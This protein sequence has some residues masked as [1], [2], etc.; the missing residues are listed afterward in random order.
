MYIYI[1]PIITDILVPSISMAPIWIASVWDD[2]VKINQYI[3]KKFS[4]VQ[5]SSNSLGVSSLSSLAKSYRPYSFYLVNSMFNT[6]PAATNCA[7]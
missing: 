7:G 2:M 6:Q 4:S 3:S 5:F 1:A